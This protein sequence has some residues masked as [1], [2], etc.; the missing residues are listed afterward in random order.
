MPAQSVT[1]CDVN[2]LTY[3]DELKRLFNIFEQSYI[4]ITELE[5]DIALE[6]SEKNEEELL[7]KKLEEEKQKINNQIKLI[8]K[9][10]K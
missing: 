5:E 4:R 7:K 9:I 3:D 2:S 8:K 1:W 6:E 10:K